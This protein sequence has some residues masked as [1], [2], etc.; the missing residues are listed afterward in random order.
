MYIYFVTGVRETPCTVYNSE[1]KHFR[2]NYLYNY[3]N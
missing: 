2:G 1:L 3:N